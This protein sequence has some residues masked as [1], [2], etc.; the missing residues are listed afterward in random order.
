MDALT[1]ITPNFAVTSALDA[2]DFGR[3][4]K[5]GFRAVINNRPDA[6]ESGQLSGRACAAHAERH[7]LSYRHIPATTL[8]LFTDAV[9]GAMAAALTSE[10]GPVLAHCKSGVRAAI[11]WA[12]ASARSQP[13]EDVLGALKAAGF[14]L[15]FLRDELDSQANR[16]RW[17][18][19]PTVAAQDAAA[20]AIKRGAAA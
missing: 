9:V 1:Y 8:D 15:G 17:M 11:V 10:R 2:D 16:A 4:A 20:A 14:E 5:L 7:G 18:G 6:E 12:A 13:V 19:E 3:L